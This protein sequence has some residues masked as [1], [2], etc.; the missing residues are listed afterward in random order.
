MPA[1]LL[2]MRDVDKRFQGVQALSAAA[3]EV[4]AAEIMAWS[5]RTAP[6]SRQ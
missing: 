5:A 3:L 1:P 6:A 2:V 4:E